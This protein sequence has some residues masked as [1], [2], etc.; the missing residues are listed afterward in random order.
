MNGVGN[1]GYATMHSLRSSMVQMLIEDGHTD[2]AI[3]K[4]TGHRVAESL[5]NSNHLLVPNGLRQQRS[6]MDAR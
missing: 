1:K 4:W 3:L 5:C 2:A 6:L